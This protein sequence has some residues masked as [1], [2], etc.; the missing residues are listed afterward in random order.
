M[1]KDTRDREP[2][3]VEREEAV[4]KDERVDEVE[5]QDAAELPDRE[6][7]SLINGNIAAPTRAAGALN[8]LGDTSTAMGGEKRAAPITR[9]NDWGAVRGQEG[10]GGPGTPARRAVSPSG[11]AATAP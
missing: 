8:A 9:W 4:V 3:D 6:A 5:D 7:M 10:G 2:A 11:T 1:A